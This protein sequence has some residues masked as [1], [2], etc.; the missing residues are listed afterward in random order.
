MLPFPF[1]ENI[2]ILNIELNK[3]TYFAQRNGF[4]KSLATKK[5]KHIF[6]RRISRSCNDPI[7]SESIFSKIAKSLTS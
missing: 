5:A 2:G 4:H 1:L 7:Y 6:N 3:S